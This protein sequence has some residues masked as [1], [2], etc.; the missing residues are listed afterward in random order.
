[1]PGQIKFTQS[2]I[3]EAANRGGLVLRR[4]ITSRDDT[5]NATV[6]TRGQTQVGSKVP[7]LGKPPVRSG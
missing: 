4:S 3:G 2:R 7:I 1:M 5:S 6:R